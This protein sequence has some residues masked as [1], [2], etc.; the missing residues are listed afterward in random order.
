MEPNFYWVVGSANV[1]LRGVGV[2][3][4]RDPAVCHWLTFFFILNSCQTEEQSASWLKLRVMW[5]LCSHPEL[6]YS[7][8]HD[9]YCIGPLK[10]TRK[11]PI[12]SEMW[13]KSFYT[14]VLIC[15]VVL[16]AN[17]TLH[18]H[19]WGPIHIP[20]IDMDKY[21]IYL[22]LFLAYRRAIDSSLCI[23]IGIW[24]RIVK[25]HSNQQ[26]TISLQGEA[27]CKIEVWRWWLK[28]SQMQLTTRI[29]HISICGPTNPCANIKQNSV[30]LLNVTL[31]SS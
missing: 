19:M 24:T 7:S 12:T 2:I 26:L 4:P 5:L 27:T 8:K 13:L 11:V 17:K 25:E 15:M 20:W 22:C 1:A 3:A 16:K 23:L 18:C 6:W 21:S 10:R 14:I 28:S 9:L 29:Q 30:D 31:V